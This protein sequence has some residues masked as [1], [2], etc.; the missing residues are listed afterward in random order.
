M[1]LRVIAAVTL[2][3]AVSAQSFWEGYARF[4]LYEGDGVGCDDPSAA[5]YNGV[6]KSVNTLEYGTLCEEDIFTPSNSNKMTV[7]CQ[8]SGVYVTVYVC[9]GSTDC[10][11]CPETPTYVEE[12][13]WGFWENP[14][15]DSCLEVKTTQVATS[16]KRDTSAMMVTDWGNATTT[17]CKYGMQE[18][19]RKNQPS[20]RLCHQLSH[21]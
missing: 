8:E 7:T 17:Y 10:S 2:L 14:T 4:R 12:Q 16:S 20:H 6:S 1:N 5:A 3:S 9:P 13:S 21:D 11:T 15:S 18:N 19:W